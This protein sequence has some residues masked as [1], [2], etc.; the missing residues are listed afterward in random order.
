[1]HLTPEEVCSGGGRAPPA[2]TGQNPVRPSAALATG[3]R[4][5]HFHA[6]RSAGRR[7]P[8]AAGSGRA[9]ARASLRAGPPQLWRC[10][11][12]VRRISCPAPLS[13]LTAAVGHQGRWP[14][15][16]PGGVAVVATFIA[17]TLNL[18]DRSCCAT[19]MMGSLLAWP[20]SRSLWRT[21][22]VR[23][24]WS[25]RG[26]HGGKGCIVD[27]AVK[28]QRYYIIPINILT[29]DAPRTAN[30]PYKYSKISN[31]KVLAPSICS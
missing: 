22:D 2:L 15:G 28:L 25:E 17:R 24:G 1:M 19:Q 27:C 11:P 30:C 23:Q 16:M 29:L 8:T 3:A 7:I 9:A 21:Q 12:Q 31:Y 14:G 26:K 5:R 18:A 10:R 6:G 20:G 13:Y 4:L